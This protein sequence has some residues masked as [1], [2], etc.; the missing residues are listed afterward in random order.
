MT[1]N[2][3]RSA[4]AC[5]VTNSADNYAVV[6]SAIGAFKATGSGFENTGSDLPGL[7]AVGTKAATA[8]ATG[9]YGSVYLWA[10][11]RAQL[12][13]APTGRG[14]GGRT[15]FLGPWSA[16]GSKTLPLGTRP[17]IN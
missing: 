14:V 11:V 2:A 3:S 12:P 9:S 5:D 10:C 13:D 1:R 4:P 6:E 15:V 7:A 16:V 8:T 17:R